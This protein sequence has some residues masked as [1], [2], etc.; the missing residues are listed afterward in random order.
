MCLT[1]LANQSHEILGRTVLKISLLSPLTSPNI[2]ITLVDDLLLQ[3]RNAI[4][5]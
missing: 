2:Y 3:T 5:L 4:F 1:V